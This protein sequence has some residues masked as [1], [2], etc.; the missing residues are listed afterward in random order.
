MRS[1]P[2]RREG[3]LSLI[4]TRMR[5]FFQ[6]FAPWIFVGI[7]PALFLLQ[8]SILPQGHELDA[9][10]PTP[11]AAPAASTVQDTSRVAI[12][13]V[14][15]DD[16]PQQI[17]RTNQKPDGNFG[18][19]AQSL[20]Q[21]KIAKTQVTKISLGKNSAKPLSDQGFWIGADGTERNDNSEFSAT[22]KSFRDCPQESGDDRHQCF[23]KIL[24]SMVHISGI[25]DSMQALENFVV[26][27]MDKWRDSECHLLAHEIGREGFERYQENPG[28][29][30]GEC[31][32]R[33]CASGGCYHGFVLEFLDVKQR[34]DPTKELTFEDFAPICAGIPLS[35]PQITHGLCLHGMGHA[36]LIYK[37]DIKDALA[38]CDGFSDNGRIA[39]Y[40]GVFHETTNESPV[41]PVRYNRANDPIYPCNELA[42]RYLDFCYFYAAGK[43]MRMFPEYIQDYPRAMQF[44]DEEAP[45][46]YIDTCYYGV[47]T[48]LIGQPGGEEKLKIAADLCDI[49][50]D[51][52][53]DAGCYY[54]ALEQVVKQDYTGAN[55]R[56][57]ALCRLFKRDAGKNMCYLSFGNGLGAGN[58]EVEPMVTACLG[59]EAPYVITCLRATGIA[60]VFPITMRWLQ[61][62][63][64]PL[65]PPLI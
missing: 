35:E 20:P 48:E 2:K 9:P 6:Q 63:F 12:N 17:G 64:S 34:V 23:A 11:L 8:G 55:S 10:L 13:E 26:A 60:R 50:A 56:A 49:H 5:S 46:K 62:M 15:Q 22:P 21:I 44:C 16:Q 1:H 30:F 29:H 45:A 4:G 28:A 27:H 19:D 31:L 25:P 37:E 24:R 54:G 33:A 40:V 51:P 41:R 38:L 3:D 14:L 53:Y 65:E 57:Y 39:C 58:T 42:D 47:V 61:E 36:F 18:T 43:F 32:P 52:R 59:V 7:L